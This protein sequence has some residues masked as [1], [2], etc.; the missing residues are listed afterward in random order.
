MIFSTISILLPTRGRVQRLDRALKSLKS[1][2]HDPSKVE[3]IFRC[4]HDDEET[5]DYLRSHEEFFLVGPREKGYASLPKFMNQCASVSTG[6]IIMMLND[7]IIV[8]TQDWDLRLLDFANKFQ[9]GIFN[10]GIKTGLNDNLFPFSIISRLAYRALGFVNDERLVFSD[11]FLLDV[12]NS[13]G[14]AIRLPSV[15]IIHEWAGN[16]SSDITRV[17]ASKHENALVF[18]GTPGDANDPKRNWQKSYKDLHEKAVREAVEKLKTALLDKEEASLEPAIINHALLESN[19]IAQDV[20]P[21]K[22]WDSLVARLKFKEN[23]GQSALIAPLRNRKIAKTWGKIFGEVIG[24]EYSP[25]VDTSSYY[26]PE[27]SHNVKIYKGPIARTEF[28]FHFRD[29]CLGPQSRVN[30]PFSCLIIENE[31]YPVSS[32]PISMAVYYVLKKVL[33]PGASIVFIHGGKTA[34]THANNDQLVRHL[35]DAIDGYRHSIE[36]FRDSETGVG[37][38]VEIYDPLTLTKSLEKTSLH[39]DSFD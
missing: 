3:I 29:I 6:D 39:Q 25:T 27:R 35:E 28:L 37:F 15:T 9:D 20:Y 4:D 11:I 26:S 36:S 32:Y 31:Q 22:L 5:Q 19:R 7:D 2:A 34:G 18:D 38:S 30:S 24:L 13:F 1:H 21:D 14:R 17:E 10:I 8:E 23:I 16:D 33:A 12:M